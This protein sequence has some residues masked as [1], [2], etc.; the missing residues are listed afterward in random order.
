MLLGHFKIFFWMEEVKLLFCR[1]PKIIGRGK[2]TGRG[3]IWVEKRWSML[4][5]NNLSQNILT[6]TSTEKLT[7]GRNLVLRMLGKRCR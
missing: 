1:D 6:F 2:K 5:R 4:F 7:I 3:V